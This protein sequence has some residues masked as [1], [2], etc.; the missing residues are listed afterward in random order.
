M[1]VTW[2]YSSQQVFKSLDVNYLWMSVDKLK[3]LI[4][5]QVRF[6]IFPHINSPS[7]SR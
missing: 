3:V 1:Y 7:S 5:Q 4:L 6:F 2:L